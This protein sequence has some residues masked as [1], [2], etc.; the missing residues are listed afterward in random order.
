MKGNDPSRP[1]DRRATS[2]NEGMY[3]DRE[4]RDRDRIEKTKKKK[5][6]RAEIARKPEFEGVRQD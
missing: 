3:D 1:R 4:A 6:S 2:S 5:Q